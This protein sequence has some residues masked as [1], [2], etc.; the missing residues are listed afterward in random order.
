VQTEDVTKAVEVPHVFE[1]T[2]GRDPTGADSDYLTLDRSSDTT[3]GLTRR[4]VR[5]MVLPNAA[6]IGVPA[7]DLN[8]PLRAGVGDRPPRIDDAKLA[9]RLVAWIRLRPTERL[10]S[11]RVSWV[12]INAVDIENRKTVTGKIVATS[13]L[14]AA[15]RAPRRLRPMDAVARPRARGSR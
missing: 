11:F 15:G 4:G 6:N 3:G 14:R 7:A 13:S 2:T 1:I 5:R 10:D 12:G 8:D 9:Q